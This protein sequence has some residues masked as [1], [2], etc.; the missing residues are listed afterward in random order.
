MITLLQVSSPSNLHKSIANL[1]MAVERSAVGNTKWEYTRVMSYAYVLIKSKTIRM[2]SSVSS[3]A[4]MVDKSHLQFSAN[5]TAI[6]DEI[7]RNTPAILTWQFIIWEPC[8]M[9]TFVSISGCGLLHK[10]A[11]QQDSKKA[12]SKN[13]KIPI[14]RG[15]LVGSG[16]LEMA[17]WGLQAFRGLSKEINHV[18]VTGVCTMIT[19][20]IDKAHQNPLRVAVA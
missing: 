16:I 2:G 8:L 1:Y 14:H 18:L 4:K 5:S 10:Q 20:G 7:F 6:I 9:T 3:Q 15:G 17:F 11:R 19:W 13:L 12:S